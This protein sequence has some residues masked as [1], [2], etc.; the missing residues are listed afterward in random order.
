M[1]ASIFSRLMMGY[2]LLVVL[3]A[4]ASVYAV[5][6]LGK[7]RDVTHSILL[8]DTA[9]VDIHKS[10]TDVLLSETRYDK[11]FVIM[12]DQALHAEFLGANREFEGL[13]NQA[14][15]RVDSPEVKAVLKEIADLHDD[16][17]ALFEE[18]AGML[19][20][21]QPYSAGWY[22]ETKD[23]FVNAMLE[24][25]ARVRTLS[26]G[27]IVTKVTK[28]NEAGASA[29]T[30]AMIITAVSLAVGIVIS[31]LITRSITVPLT[32]MERKTAEIGRGIYK[33]DL[34]LTSPPEI[35][36][37]A[38]AFN[39]MSAKLKEVDTMKSDFYSLMSHELRTPLTSIKEGTNLFLEGHGGP[40]TEKQKRLLTIIAEESNRLIGLVSSLLDLSRLE[41]GMLPYQ[42]VRADLGALITK[43]LGEVIPLAEAK[44]IR[45][46]KDV[47]PSLTAR[48]DAE[49]ILQVLRNLLGNALKFTPK[50]G[51]VRIAAR[52]VQRSGLNAGTGTPDAEPPA[53]APDHGEKLV[54]ISVED[55]G[56]GIPKDHQAAI[57][58]KFRQVTL[59]GAAKVPGTGLGLAIVQHIVNDHGG[60][61]WVKSVEGLGS[62]FT[63]VLPA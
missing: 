48:V 42:F 47:E 62:T 28:L 9:I 51:S 26:Q 44:Q 54:E 63:F 53:A 37:L 5:V 11:K 18:E 45:I 49:R 41:A 39:F 12:N 61:V 38:R 1:R 3:S 27:G 14:F 16:Y 56:P 34:D 36:A 10:L 22:G 52:H 24:D 35:G 6:Q 8:V 55:T 30:A 7:I 60:A 58:D 57:F 31:L 50:G 21:G 29:T 2:V 46:R 20:A 33:A 15:D 23:R 17:R 59:A 13:L 43:A 25:L 19:A 40:V 4:S 32:R